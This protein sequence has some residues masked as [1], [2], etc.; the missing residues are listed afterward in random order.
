MQRL[1]IQ[2]AIEAIDTPNREAGHYIY[3]YYDGDTTFY[4]GRS[5]HPFERLREHL[6]QG[7]RLPLPDAIGRLI[8]DNH[9]DSLSW[10][11]E[12]YGLQELAPTL[13]LSCTSLLSMYADRLEDEAIARFQPCLNAINNP[14]GARLPV[15]YHRRKVA[16]LKLPD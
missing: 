15:K 11:M 16:P 7:E 1:T 13:D 8:L 9:P 14:T 2:E 5:V 3:R 6:G 4:V 12:I 10:V